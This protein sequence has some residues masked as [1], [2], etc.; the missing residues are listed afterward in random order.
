[1]VKELL[2][3]EDSDRFAEIFERLAN[4]PAK[5]QA[6][7]SDFAE[8]MWEFGSEALVKLEERKRTAMLFSDKY[9]KVSWSKEH[10]VLTPVYERYRKY[11][12]E[13]ALAFNEM[14]RDASRRTEAFNRALNA[15]KHARSLMGFLWLYLGRDVESSLRGRGL[16]LSTPRRGRPPEGLKLAIEAWELKLLE[17]D[18]KW[19]WPRLAERFCIYEGPGHVHEKRCHERLKQSVAVLKR[20]LRECGISLL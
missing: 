20:K 3:G 16:S 13:M 17:P 1:V 5:H 12:V 2:P 9:R 15:R 10:P 4:L 14:R 8:A 6:R 7:A 19:T 18:R 11:Y